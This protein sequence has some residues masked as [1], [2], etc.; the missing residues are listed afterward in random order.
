MDHE[1]LGIA[2][3]GEVARKSERVYRF[4]RNGMVAL[5]T[6]AQ[7]TAVRIV[8]EQLLGAFVVRMTIETQIR[9]PSDFG[10]L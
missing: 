6:E 1:C 4:A 8:A 3:V 10:V 9:D 7:H 2:H 5:D